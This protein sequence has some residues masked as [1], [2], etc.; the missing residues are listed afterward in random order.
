ME[1]P[2]L[3]PL[4]GV[5]VTG[6]DTGVGKT[7]IAAG[8]TAVLRQWGLKAVYF[9]PVQ[10]GCPQEDGRLVPTDARMAQDLAGLREPLE[11]LTPITLRLPLAPGVAAQHEGATVDLKKVAA[12]IR[13]LA[14][15]YEFLVVEGAGGLYVPLIGTIF[16]VRDLIPWLHLPL[17]VVARAG[18]GTIN[19]TA[20]TVMA[21]RHLGLPVAGVILNRYPA[22]PSLA[23]E[24]NPEVI[25]AITEV[26]V[27]GKI[28]EVPEIT[29]PAGR[30]TF[31]AAMDEACRNLAQACAAR[32]FLECMIEK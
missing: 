24:T 6:T 31:L 27:L 12:S 29:S 17:L 14:S 9:K 32:A 28:P 13:D 1:L 30:R 2:P 11:L 23:E 20:L 26:P 15:R 7:W 25:E 19:H 10:S 5:F 3:P 21:A 22:K 16:L 4:K 8:V 18:L